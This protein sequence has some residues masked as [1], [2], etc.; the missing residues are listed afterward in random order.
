MKS[1]FRMI[2]LA[3]LIVSCNLYASTTVSPSMT[4]M[5]GEKGCP[6]AAKIWGW[7]DGQ[8]LP[9]RTLQAALNEKN[10]EQFVIAPQSVIDTVLN[11]DPNVVTDYIFHCDP[12]KQLKP[13][14]LI[15]FTLSYQ[16]PSSGQSVTLPEIK[17]LNVPPA[18]VM[19]PANQGVPPNAPQAPNPAN[20]SA[21]PEPNAATQ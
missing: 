9:A 14:E 21:A 11:L 13:E 19:P 18:G 17:V 2:G 1:V 3:A 10:P 12:K 15:I 16:D 5:Q 7:K 6:W 20:P 4:P 8:D